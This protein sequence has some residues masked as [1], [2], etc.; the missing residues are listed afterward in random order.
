MNIVAWI[1]LVTLSLKHISFKGHN[2]NQF[3]NDVILVH[4]TFLIALL[5]KQTKCPDFG[6]KTILM[7]RLII[8]ILL[9]CN[10]YGISEPG[11]L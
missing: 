1:R 5:S 7:A 10:L 8:N 4:H 9:I 3:E 6:G 2:F 11:T